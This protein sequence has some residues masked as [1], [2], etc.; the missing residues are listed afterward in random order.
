M[1]RFIIG[2]LAAR[3]SP[4]DKRIEAAKTINACS[5]HCTRAYVDKANI[6]PVEDKAQ[7]VKLL[8]VL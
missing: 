4:A 1:I 6:K 2:E 5:H 7:S 8:E 3:G